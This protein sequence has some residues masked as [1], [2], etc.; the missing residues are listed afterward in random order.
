MRILYFFFIPWIAGAALSVDVSARSAILMNAETGAILFEKQAHA[1]MYPAST[2][3]L[4]TALFVLDGKRAELDQS[5]LVSEMALRMKAARAVPHELEP[6]GTMMGLRKGEILPLDA[7]LHGMIL[8]SGNDA[9]NVIAEA[10][11]G[12][13]PQFMSEMN[14][15]LSSIGCSRT[16]YVNPH[17]LHHPDHA[18]TAY[19]LATM[20]R[21]GLSIPKFRTLL[22]TVSYLRPKSNKSSAEEI[23]TFNQLLKPGK[24]YYPKLIGGK[25][26]YHSQS[27]AT[28]AAAA[29]HEGRTLIAVVLGC[30][31]GGRYDDI[32]RL[33]E[34]AFS[35]SKHTRVVIGA[36]R[37]FTQ[38]LEGAEDFLLAHLS[39]PL[40]IS[41]FPSEEPKCRAFIEWHDLE[42]P[43]TQG[44]IVGE[45]R[46]VDESERLVEKEPLVASSP[47]RGTLW[48]RIKRMFF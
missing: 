40:A 26:G 42:L 27:M 21:Q 24:Y 33:F 11:S 10:L 44:Q 17:G 48:H 16:F 15:Y 13:I 29:E 41:Y 2:T 47:L 18:T 14:A 43:I 30:S 9:A 25:T 4:G 32:K 46:I 45:V 12:S 20:M 6:D 19:D 37:V 36:D 31:K 22:S 23:V 38:S 34:T 35:E 7:L 1:S 39:Q 8:V 3:K 5:I 28:L